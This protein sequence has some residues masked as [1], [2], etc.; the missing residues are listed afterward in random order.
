M[1]VGTVLTGFVAVRGRRPRAGRRSRC[2]GVELLPAPGVDGGGSVPERGRTCL[3]C[4][5]G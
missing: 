5:L 3:L 2:Q 1:G 4:G